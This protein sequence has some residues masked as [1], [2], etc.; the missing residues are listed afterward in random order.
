[1]SFGNVPAKQKV[2]QCPVDRNLPVEATRAAETWLHE[3][4]LCDERTAAAL[5]ENET[6]PGF[7][8]PEEVIAVI[9]LATWQGHAAARRYAI[10]KLATL[11]MTSELT[12]L[13]KIWNLIYGVAPGYTPPLYPPY[14]RSATGTPSQ[15]VPAPLPDRRV[16]LQCSYAHLGCVDTQCCARSHPPTISR[17]S[18]TG[19]LVVDDSGARW[20]QTTASEYRQF[21]AP[22]TEQWRLA[23]D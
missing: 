21:A 1:M 22:E 16:V 18:R 20:A 13:Q 6:A 14:V 19:Q 8:T 7:R 10:E 5:P 2:L 11:C 9:R 12:E 4:L 3:R 15:G 17:D 23:R